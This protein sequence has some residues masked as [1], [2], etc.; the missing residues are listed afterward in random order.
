MMGYK[1]SLVTTRPYLF[2]TLIRHASWTHVWE[3]WG[4]SRPFP[5]WNILQAGALQLNLFS[6]RTNLQQ[7]P[8]MKELEL[9]ESNEWLSF[10]NK[11]SSH[12]IHFANIVGV[13]RYPHACTPTY[14]TFLCSMEFILFLHGRSSHSGHQCLLLLWGRV[15]LSDGNSECVLLPLRMCDRGS[16][17]V[18]MFVLALAFSTYPAL[19]ILKKT[20]P[21]PSSV[22]CPHCA[23]LPSLVKV[24]TKPAQTLHC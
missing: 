14:S 4:T 11:D 17:W 21:V 24:K 13:I 7:W 6:S 16:G 3:K 12:L 8:F 20:C 5:E 23:P 22:H 18:F 2:H 1:K 10:T 9:G 19:G 15:N